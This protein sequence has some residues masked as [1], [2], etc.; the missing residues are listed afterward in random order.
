MAIRDTL[1]DAVCGQRDQIP[2][3]LAVCCVMG[4]LLVFPLALLEQGT[5]GYTIAVLDGI[6]VAVC[7]AVLGPTYWYCVKRRMD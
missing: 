4:L 6:L 5:V 1:V 2:L 3:I 7:L